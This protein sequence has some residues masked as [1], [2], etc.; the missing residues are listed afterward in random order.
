[1]IAKNISPYSWD[2][3]PNLESFEP[4]EKYNLDPSLT[5]SVSHCEFI[6]DFFN[7]FIDDQMVDF[8]VS[9]SNSKL[10]LYSKDK[11]YIYKLNLEPITRIEIRAFFGLLL[12]FGALKKTN[13]DI[14]ELWSEDGVDNVQNCYY[15]TA[16][17]SRQRFKTISCC[18][19]F[20]EMETREQRKINDP[21]F[22]KMRY[23]FNI[24]KKN[25]QEAF[26][27]GYYLCIDE[28]L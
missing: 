28:T 10:A 18:I 23:V 19:S 25:I 24:F 2:K 21:K 13:V 9:S 5:S 6:S 14:N 7:F 11:S 22:F 8:I 17:M 27:P 4:L 1:M 26:V 12:L 15:A 20:D 16:T 3:E